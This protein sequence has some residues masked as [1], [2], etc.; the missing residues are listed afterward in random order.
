VSSLLRAGYLA[1]EEFDA[2]M[3]QG[4]VGDICARHFDQYGHKAAHHLDERLIGVTL[5]EL[6]KVPT[7][8]GVAYTKAKA[9]ALLAALRGGYVNILVTD[10]EAAEEVLRLSEEQRLSEGQHALA[11]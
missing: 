10:S 5:D 8:I 3:S 2:L 1:R 11:K 4:V 9:A 6:S 7:V